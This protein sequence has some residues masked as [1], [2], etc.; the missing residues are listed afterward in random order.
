MRQ[1]I[2]ISCH[3]LRQLVV[4]NWPQLQGARSVLYEMLLAEVSLDPSDKGGNPVY[5]L[6][7]RVVMYCI[8]W[9]F[10]EYMV[11]KPLD[12]NCGFIDC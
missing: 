11:G 10:V 3:L 5:Y 9:G 2:G 7:C 6:M 4:A 1:T 8:S 12:A